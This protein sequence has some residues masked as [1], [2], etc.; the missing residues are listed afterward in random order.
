MEAGENVF[1]WIWDGLPPAERIIFSAVASAADENAVIAADDLLSLLQH[2]GIRIL[3]RELE[4][5]PRVLI[6]WEMLRCVAG[7][8]G[9]FIE[10]MRR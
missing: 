1:E 6:E 8:H 5:A 10:L 2:H 3:L 7:G 4:L 9:F